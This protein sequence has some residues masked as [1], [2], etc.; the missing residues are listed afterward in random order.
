VNAA[1]ESEQEKFQSDDFRRIISLLETD[2]QRKRSSTP[3]WAKLAFVSTHPNS[4]MRIVPSS[5][6]LQQQHNVRS[7]TVSNDV[8]PVQKKKKIVRGSPDSSCDQSIDRNV[9]YY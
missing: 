8:K 3:E 1:V 5:E 9:E 4:S 7:V 2:R 6:S